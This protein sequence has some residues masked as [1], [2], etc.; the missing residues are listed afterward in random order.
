MVPFEKFEKMFLKAWA[1][2]KIDPWNWQRSV[3][4][5]VFQERLTDRLK[6]EQCQYMHTYLYMHTYAQIFIN[7]RYYQPRI[8]LK[9]L[10]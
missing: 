1:K 5:S 6:L 9:L 10:L 3:L 8:Y 2:P 4:K 7:W